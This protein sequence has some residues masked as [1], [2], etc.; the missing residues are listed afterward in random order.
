METTLEPA[1]TQH[2]QH[3]KYTIYHPQLRHHFCG[4][5]DTIQS[6]SFVRGTGGT[7]LLDR[8]L[9]SAGSR[10]QVGN[11]TALQTTISRSSAACASIGLGG[12]PRFHL[13]TARRTN[14]STPNTPTQSY[15]LQLAQLAILSPSG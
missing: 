9:C 4:L 13:Y 2:Q 14:S 15:S 6:A 3:R 7:C 1:Q 11:I 8:Q 10:C 12:S 5:G